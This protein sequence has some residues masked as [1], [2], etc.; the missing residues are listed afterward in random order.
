MD[1]SVKQNTLYCKILNSKNEQPLSK[2]KGIGIE[3]VQKRLAYLYPDGHE[4][5][6][7]D[8]GDFFAVSLVLELSKVNTSLTNPRSIAEEPV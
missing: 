3:N 6:L 5:K 2:Q 1:I 7:N 4:L 8:E